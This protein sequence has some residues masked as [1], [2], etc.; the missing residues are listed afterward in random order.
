MAREVG[1]QPTL[2]L[3][4]RSAENLMSSHVILGT[5]DTMWRKMEMEEDRETNRHII[6]GAKNIKQGDGPVGEWVGGF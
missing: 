4:S 5:K 2:V 1:V 6:H 3:F